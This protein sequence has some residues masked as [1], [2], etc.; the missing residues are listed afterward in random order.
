MTARRP[1]RLAL[2]IGTRPEAIKLAPLA[3][4]CAA[5][6]RFDHHIVATRQHGALFD[7]ALGAFDLRADASLPLDW[8]MLPR[9]IGARTRAVAAAVAGLLHAGRFD[10]LLVQGDTTSAHGAARG[11]RAAGVPIGHVEAGL[12]SGDI[13]RPWPEE[14]HRIGIDRLAALLFA[15]TPEAL[16]NLAEEPAVRGQALVTGNTG[17]DALLTMRRLLQRRPGLSRLDALLAGDARPLLLVTCHRR[18]AFG[19]PVERVCDALLRLA[20][21]GDV[22]ILL[23]LHPNPRARLPVAA[24]LG[25]HPAI[26]LADPLDYPTMV[27]AM[28]RARLILSDSG[29]IQEEAPAL[30][31]PLLVLREVTERP[32]ALATG[33]L[34]LVGHDPALILREASRLLDDDRAHAAMSRP[35]FPFGDGSA[36]GRIL[37]AIAR[38]WQGRR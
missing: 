25:G 30:G 10:M 9:A 37:D 12:R 17:I 20:A 18:E 34:R 8:S 11:G 19:A 6:A 15:P 33:N 3:R 23:P 32:E 5:D 14:A 36:S 7:D 2:V 21:R 4:A 26:T 13:R 27:D 22:R 1:L 28:G 16:R 38:H 35:A 31:L 24:R 29:G